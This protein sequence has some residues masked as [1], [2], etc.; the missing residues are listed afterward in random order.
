MVRGG[1]CCAL[2]GGASLAIFRAM[3]SLTRREQVLVAFVLLA[4]CTGLGVKH[5]RDG[6]ALAPL[7]AGVQVRR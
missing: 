1:E 2:A 3:F 5:W 6:R 4:F 7:Q